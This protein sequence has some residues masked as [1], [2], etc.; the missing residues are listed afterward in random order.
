MKIEKKIFLEKN[1]TVG[2]AIK[3]LSHTSAT[4]VI[5]NIP[6]DAE[7]ATS[8]EN[9]HMLA[10]AALNRKKILSIE[11]VDDRVVELASLAHITALNSIF[12]T[13]ERAVSDI[14][15][16]HTK[17]TVSEESKKKKTE[18]KKTEE[19]EHDYA[20]KPSDEG[21]VKITVSEERT[22]GIK[23]DAVLQEIFEGR[24]DTPNLKEQK[25]L[26]R[27]IIIF[28]RPK[29]IRGFLTGLIVMLLIVAV[30]GWFVFVKLP[31]ADISLVLKKTTIPLDG[32]VLIA[33]DITAPSFTTG[34][35]TIPGEMLSSRQNLQ[36]EFTANGTTSVAQKA[37]G[38]LTIYNA[39][40]SKSQ[41]LVATT[42]FMSPDGKIMRL[43]EGITI[44]AA[45]VENGKIVPSSIK[46][47]I[48]ADGAGPDYNFSSGIKWTIPGFKGT[49]KYTGFYAINEDAITGG[50]TGERAAPTEKDKA[51]AKT[52]IEESLKN[53]LSTQIQ[54]LMT[55][56]L[57]LL[58][59]ATLFSITKETTQPV[60][61]KS[62]M[63]S[64]YAEGVIQ[65]FVFDEEMLKQALTNKA[66]QSLPGNEDAVR[67][68]ISYGTPNIDFQKGTMSLPVTGSVVFA[69]HIDVEA[70]TSSLENQ[71]ESAVRRTIFSL[72][73]LENATVTLW[74][75]WV[76]QVPADPQKINL[77]IE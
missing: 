9:F 19:P 69:A 8:V 33:S 40:D 6:S 14:V 50:S 47:T 57:K 38:T 17:K 22:E 39:F 4:K 25:K 67:L 21:D 41:P 28:R 61:G 53:A 76:H 52:K 20:K 11:S 15:A 3:Y 42:R 48:T 58:D 12:R 64:V 66:K 1:E 45:K 27:K 72:P 13:S 31:E 70:L 34:N 29:S 63:F 5:L 75:F 43:N 23:K 62:N 73:G 35:V 32:T 60:E 49:S 16:R 7:I 44:P 74:P 24:R 30:A 2:D 56:N 51:D 59:G 65:E 54:L 26:R 36:M 68:D 71:D 46:A 55:K 37:E 10:A 18:I 77:S